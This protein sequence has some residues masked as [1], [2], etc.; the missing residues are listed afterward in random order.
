M[1]DHD[2][3]EKGEFLSKTQ[4]Y[5]N[6]S[7]YQEALDLAESWLKQ[8]PMNADA[9]IVCCH[10]FMRMG[11]LDRVEDV[12]AR[13]DDA[14]LQLSKVFSFMGDLCLEGRLTGEAIRFYRKFLSVNPESTAA[15]TIS[16]K[17]QRLTSSEETLSRE[18]NGED[19]DHTGQVAPD[20]YTV[21][22]ADLYIRQ[23]YFQMAKDVLNEILKM[24]PHHPLAAKR[25]H[26]V[27]GML[28][29]MRHKEE[30]VRELT[31]WLKNIDRIRYG[32]A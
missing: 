27:E 18:D 21:T 8:H 29:T 16:E 26:E 19:D 23:G 17:L 12:L 14:I 24:E 20:F 28:E 13:V 32:A 7:L 4:G 2:L 11:K 31:R 3:K 9:Y 15:K 30:V 22:L 25:I 5:L 1:S 10:A 6:E